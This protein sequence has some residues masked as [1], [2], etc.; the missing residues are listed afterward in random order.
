MRATET[1]QT[2]GVDVSR[3]ITLSA[4]NL[5][6]TEPPFLNNAAEYIGYDKENGNLYGR[7]V[8]LQLDVKW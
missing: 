6:N 2:D 5:F 7:R 8:S 3:G 1:L 4:L